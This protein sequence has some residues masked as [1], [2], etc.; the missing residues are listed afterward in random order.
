VVGR[1]LVLAALS[2]G[3]LVAAGT[4]P[5]SAIAIGGPTGFPD[6]YSTPMNTPLHV[7]APGVLANDTN[8]IL[9]PMTAVQDTNT[10]AVTQGTVTLNSNGSLDFMPVPGFFGD[11]TFLYHPNNG[12]LLDAVPNFAGN[13]TV[14]TITV[15]APNRPPIGVDDSYTMDANTSLEVGAPGV[16]GNDSDPDGDPITAVPEEGPFHGE[17]ILNADGSF[18]YT[19]APDF[20]GTDTFTYHPDDGVVTFQTFASGNPTTVTINV[21]AP[22]SPG[23][24]PGSGPPPPPVPGCP[25]APFTDVPSTNV[26]AADID[27]L[28]FHG[29]TVGTTPT[30]YS[31]SNLVTRGEIAS[32]IV[33]LI[34]QAGGSVPANPPDVFTDDNGDVHEHEINQLAALGIAEGTSA[35]LYDPSGSTTRGQIASLLVRAWTIVKGTV[36]PVTSDHFTDDTGDAHEHDI[37]AAFEKGFVVGFPDGTFRPNS[38]LPRD[39]MASFLMREFNA[40]A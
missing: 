16:L 24:G 12:V 7:N 20:V 15:T 17:S 14:V 23:P 6:A 22:S 2:A 28:F 8:P 1:V 33:R 9:G 34:T 21:T 4:A 26:H 11:A 18:T 10:D 19:P 36:L 3:G 32:F 5:A 29:I 40:F 37:N 31:P 35:G 27:C 38:P 30:A 39:E 25:A 13:P